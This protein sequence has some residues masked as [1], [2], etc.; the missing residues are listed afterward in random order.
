MKNFIQS[1]EVVEVIAPYD[2][3][4]G[5][6]VLVGGLFGYATHAALTGKPVNI[7]TRG[8]FEG[9]KTS[10]QAWATVG[11]AIYWDN[12][13]RELTT[14]VSTNTLVAKNLAAAVNPSATG[15]VRLNG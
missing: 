3:A 15:T 10:A 12:A 7:K 1:G 9:K 13:A 8:V 4:S 11:L 14:T 2:V 5:D 6:G